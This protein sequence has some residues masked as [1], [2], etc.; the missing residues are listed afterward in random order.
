VE[1]QGW[2]PRGT[3]ILVVA[4][5][6]DVLEIKRSKKSAPEV[7]R[8][9]AFEDAL[10]SVGERAITQQKPPASQSQIPAVIP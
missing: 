5:I 8:I 9:I 4:G 2:H 10:A 6:C 3:A 1:A 7:G